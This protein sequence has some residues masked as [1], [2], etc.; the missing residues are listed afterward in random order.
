MKRSR[1]VMI[2]GVL[3]SVAMI[4]TWT[5]TFVFYFIILISGKL[6]LVIGWFVIVLQPLQGAFNFLIYLIPVFRKMLKT[7]RLKKTELEKKTL[8]D[9]ENN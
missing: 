9:N 5:F 4:L 8:D 6:N 2:Q 1:R 7:R 3:Y